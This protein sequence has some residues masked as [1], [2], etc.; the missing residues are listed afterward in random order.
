ML[1]RDVQIAV[2]GLLLLCTMSFGQSVADAAKEARER[3]QQ[4]DAAQ[5]RVYTDEDMKPASAAD[6]V[7]GGTGSAAMPSGASLSSVSLGAQWNTDLARATEVYRRI[8]G[9]TDPHASKQVQDAAKKEGEEALA[10]LKTE[11]EREEKIVKDL[12]ADIQSLAAEERKE[13]AGVTDA[14]AIDDVKAKYASQREQKNAD[15]MSHSK[16]AGKMGLD[17]F[18]LVNVCMEAAGIS[19]PNK[20]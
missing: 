14:K 18:G 1:K 7:G 4:T 19:G 11:A 5:K 17:M 16:I 6:I 8:C 12:R 20:H 10:P 9:I 15:L 2:W 13:I 3:K